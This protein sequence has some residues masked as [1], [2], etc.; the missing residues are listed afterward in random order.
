MKRWAALLAVVVIA[1]GT[2]GAFAL[3]RSGSSAAGTEQTVAGSRPAAARPAV[4]VPAVVVVRTSG[5]TLPL[6]RPLT[7]TVSA[8]TLADVSVADAQGTVVPGALDLASVTWTSSATLVPE[9][10]YS[11]VVDARDANGDAHPSTVSARTPPAALQLHG[12]LSPGDDAVVGVGSPLRVTFDAPVAA[13]DRAAVLQRLAVTTTPAVDGAWRW[14]SA[15]EVHWRP[16]H[17]WPTGTKV[18]LASTLTGLALSGGRWGSGAHTTDFTIGADHESVADTTKHTLVVKS[19]GT[20]V[21][22]FDMS[23]GSPTFPSKSGVH[24][25]LEKLR[26]IVMDSATVGIPKG[27]PGAYDETVYWDVR[28]SNGGAF[29]HAAPW[30]VGSQGIRNVS[31]GC[32]NLS[33]ADAT[34]FYGFSQPGDIVDV[35]H[36]GVPPLLSDPGTSEW[37]LTWAQWTAPQT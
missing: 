3:S 13:V 22:T 15:S 33:T 14:M 5:G 24:I 2:G 25:T 35:V 4:A 27:S 10:Q 30:S 23:A 11:V 26:S 29:V 7:V 32:I 37:N 16:E 36:S 19:G 6:G 21:R 34:W 28:I 12:T 20:V 1:G 9:T 17:Y 31:H 8:G 18:H